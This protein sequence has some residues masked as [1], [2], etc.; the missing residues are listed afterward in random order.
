[1]KHLISTPA[2]LH[3]CHGCGASVLAAIDQG[4]TVRVDVAPL[5]SQIEELGAQLSGRHTFD[6]VRTAGR[7]ELV[8]RDQWRI[9]KREHTILAEHWCNTQGI[10][11]SPVTPTPGATKKPSI[12]GPPHT[13]VDPPPF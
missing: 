4:L 10:K 3:T 7:I 5:R 12:N 2:C 9:A 1:M 6:V 11:S 13:N 8:H